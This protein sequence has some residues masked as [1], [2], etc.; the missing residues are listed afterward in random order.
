[1]TILDLS[2]VPNLVAM[3]LTGNTGV[4]QSPLTG[5][6]Q[7]LDRGG[8]KW[9]AQYTFTNI[10]GD[11]RANLIGT[12]AAL[13][14]QAN[15]LR[16]PIYDNAKR[17]AYGGTPL[18]DGASQTG[19]SINLKG[20]SISITQWIRKGDYISIDVN[21]EHEL[22]MATADSSSGGTGLIEVFFEPRLRTSPLDNAVVFVEDGVLTKPQG[23]FLL[24]DSSV[25]WSSQPGKPTHRS[26][27]SLAMVEDVF[28]TQ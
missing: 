18:V 10:R 20:L 17:G 24:S 7:T 22:K 12:L 1:M 19:N 13:R 11:D 6:I 21:G 28:A 2:E 14:A 26:V 5:S 8:L 25:L 9:E 3:Q 16:V 23:I 15:R 4:F 27:V